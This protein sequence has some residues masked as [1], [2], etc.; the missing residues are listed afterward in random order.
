M[1]PVKPLNVGTSNGERMIHAAPFQ[2]ERTQAVHL[3]EGARVL[4]ENALALATRDPGSLHGAQRLFLFLRPPTPRWCPSRWSDC[5]R[6]PINQSM[7]M[8]EIFF[9]QILSSHLC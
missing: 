5:V 8:R 9:P 7:L 4:R 3:S 2:S 1:T 6:L